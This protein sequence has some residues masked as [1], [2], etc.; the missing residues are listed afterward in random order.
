VQAGSCWARRWTKNP[1]PLRFYAYLEMWT[2]ISAALSP[3]FLWAARAAYLALGGSAVLGDVSATGLRLLLSALVLGVPT[4]LM[5][6]TLPAAA[7]AVETDA[8]E[9]RGKLALIYGANTSEQ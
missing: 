5:G 7:R 8:D 3:L 1:R 6:G 4:F 2:A 9:G